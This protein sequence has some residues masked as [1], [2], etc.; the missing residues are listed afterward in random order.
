METTVNDLFIKIGA[1][2]VQNEKLL[3]EN[4]RFS[5]A[6]VLLQNELN[7]LKE[8]SKPKKV[9]REKKEKDIGSN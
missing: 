1:L 7:A 8:A 2:T 5:N 3:E 6:I 4:A 9:K